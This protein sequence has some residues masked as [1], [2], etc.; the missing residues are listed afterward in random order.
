MDLDQQSFDAFLSGARL[1]DS[2]AFEALYRRFNR[3]VASFA[4]ARHAADP[5]GL[6]NETFL[7]VF[8]SIH[9]F[10][11][12]EA[13]FSGWLFRIARNLVI[14]DVRH[15]S[16][17]VHEIPSEALST[18]SAPEHIDASQPQPAAETIA[19]EGFEHG[20][21]ERH[22]DN[23]TPEQRDVILLRVVADQS[24]EVVAAALGKSISAVKSSQFRAICQLRDALEKVSV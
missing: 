6:V 12:N 1:G 13:Q 16:R 21:I 10:E 18:P 19:L 15:Q 3:P 7:R 23:L 24:I 11:G 5:E 9:S 22:L 4:S 17:R 14:D 20:D 2:A 8:R